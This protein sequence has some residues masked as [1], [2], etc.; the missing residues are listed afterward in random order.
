[1]LYDEEAKNSL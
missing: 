1:M